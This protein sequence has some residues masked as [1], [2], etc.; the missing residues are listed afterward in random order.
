MLNITLDSDAT[1]KSFITV[2]PTGEPRPTTSANNAEP[3]LVSPNSTIAKLGANGS[4]SIFNQQGQTNVIV[5]VVGYL[6]TL[7]KVSGAGGPGPAGP[8]GATGPAGPHGS[9][10]D[11][12]DGRHAGH[13]GQSDPVR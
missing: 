3:G 9:G 4:V 7:D 13:A 1:A 2:W 12:G 8:T 5:D 11:A 10:G 6:V